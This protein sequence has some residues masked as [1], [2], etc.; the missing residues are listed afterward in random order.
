MSG[1]PVQTEMFQEGLGG[2]LRPVVGKP[3]FGPVPGEE[4][5]RAGKV[6]AINCRCAA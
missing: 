2:Y 6:D 5:C 1:I 3:I 4:T